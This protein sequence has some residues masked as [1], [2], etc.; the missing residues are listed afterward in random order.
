MCFR[1]FVEDDMFS[2]IGPMARYCV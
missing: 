2:H 1:F